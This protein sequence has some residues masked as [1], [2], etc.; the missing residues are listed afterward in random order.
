MRGML[1]GE[2]M[3]KLRLNKNKKI[4][5]RNIS[6]YSQTLKLAFSPTKTKKMIKND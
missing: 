1:H 3:K 6:H 4:Q 2:N 5:I